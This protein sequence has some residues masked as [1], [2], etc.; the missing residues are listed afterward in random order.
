MIEAHF[1]D[2]PSQY[3]EHTLFKERYRSCLQ[4]ILLLKSRVRKA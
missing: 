1:Q 2:L 4:L 3:L